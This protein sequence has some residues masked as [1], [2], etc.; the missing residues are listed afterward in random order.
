[1]PNRAVILT[2][3]D[4][5]SRGEA[6]DKSGLALVELLD[7]LAA[8]LIHRD[9]VSD[10]VDAIRRVLRDWIGRC[11]LILTSGGTGVAPRD[12][13]PEAIRPLLEKELPGFGEAM[14]A[15]GQVKQ[16]LSIVS[17]SGAGT[18]GRTLIVW[19]PGS[20]RAV[21][22]SLE[23]VAPAIRHICQFLRGQPPH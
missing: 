3:S 2:I 13:T 18:A 9:L 16:P 5:C 17:R 21:K 20:P 14:R 10:D 11:E 6:E 4:R 15:A 12:V 7:D 1:M 19:L 8:T 22:E 23:P